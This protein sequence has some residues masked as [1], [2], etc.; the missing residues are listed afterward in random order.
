MKESG[1]QGRYSFGETRLKPGYSRASAHRLLY[2]RC[3]PRRGP[4]D[5]WNRTGTAGIL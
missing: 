5:R 2:P 4:H 3:F 1:F